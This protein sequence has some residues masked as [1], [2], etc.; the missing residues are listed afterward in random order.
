MPIDAQTRLIL[1]LGDPVAH[2]L[3]PLIHNAAFRAHGLNWL[4]K[5]I[6]V[7]STGLAAAVQALHAPSMVGANVTIPHKQSILPLMD[8]LSPHAEIV[9]A[10][11]TIVCRREEGAVRL[12]GDNTDVAGF[13]SPLSP[14]A[15]RLHGAPMLVFGAGGA[16]RAVIYALLSTYSP[17]R[18]TVAVRSPERATTLRDAFEHVGP[19]VEI[20]SM[21]R[22]A[23]RVR[24]SRLIVNATPVG[25]HP[26]IDQTPWSL[27]GVFPAGKIVY[28]LIYAPERTR[29]LIEAE[30]AHCAT[31]GGLEMLIAQAAA[32]YVQWT[33][34][35]MPVE[36]VRLALKSR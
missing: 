18:L 14:Y 7:S 29:L 30:A 36:A 12:H 13:L 31:I 32:A 35:P 3:S 19:G 16:A 4:Y 24:E 22:A 5:A 27:H 15:D 9:G 8:T 20:L 21:T 23:R 1:L 28:D 25:M 2:S 33:G 6:P 34:Q 11:N 26:N 10:V 17:A